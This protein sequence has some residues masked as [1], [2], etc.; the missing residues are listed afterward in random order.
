[1]AQADAAN[2]KTA[3]HIQWAGAKFSFPYSLARML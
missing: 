2:R 3:K 1:M